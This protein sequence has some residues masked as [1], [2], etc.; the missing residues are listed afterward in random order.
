MALDRQRR[1][2]TR[3]SSAA[4]AESIPN[5]AVSLYDGVTSFGFRYVSGPHEQ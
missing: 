5:T 4:A 1:C 3:T 2:A